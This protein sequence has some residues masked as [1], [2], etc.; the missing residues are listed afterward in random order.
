MHCWNDNLQNTGLLD[1]LDHPEGSSLSST[2]GQ[3]NDL[4]MLDHRSILVTI[5]STKGIM[6]QF[7]KEGYQIG[8]SGPHLLTQPD[9]FG[10]GMGLALKIL[11]L[12]SPPLGGLSIF[13]ILP[14]FVAIIEVFAQHFERIQTAQELPKAGRGERHCGQDQLFR[15]RHERRDD[16]PDAVAETAKTV[17]ETEDEWTGLLDHNGDPIYRKR[18]PFGFHGRQK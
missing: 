18:L 8:I 3:P 14:P 10:N 1:A 16:E 6:H 15:P 2:S 9:T 4:R 7:V 11:Y 5:K 17:I 13:S 12:K